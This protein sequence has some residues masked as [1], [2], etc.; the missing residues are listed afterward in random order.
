MGN[1]WQFEKARNK[2]IAYY[3]VAFMADDVEAMENIAEIIELYDAGFEELASQQAELAV[4]HYRG[5][6]FYGDEV[7][8]PADDFDD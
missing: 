3:D 1:N 7:G 4:L 6:E 5:S 2:L 8:R